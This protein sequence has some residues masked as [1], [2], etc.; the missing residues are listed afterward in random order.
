MTKE[1]NT[2]ALETKPKKHVSYEKS[3]LIWA[4]IFLAPWLIGFLLMFAFPMVESF[5]YSFY[6]MKLNTDGIM[7]YTFIGFQNYYNALQVEAIGSTIFKVEMLNTIQEVA[8][9]I[10]VIMIFSL[11][12][13][14][15]LNTE[16]KGR[17]I[18]RAIFFIPVILN[19]GAVVSAL[20]KGEAMS[21][22]L[23][24]T[25]AFGKVFELEEYLLRAGL[26]QGLVGFIVS[27]I[28]R[29]YSILSLSGVPIL[30]F[31]AS[32]QSVPRHLYEAAEIEGATKYE[33]FWLITLPNV[34]PHFLTVAIFILIDTFVSSPISKYIDMVKQT[35]WGLKASMSWLY[36]LVVAVIL[37]VIIAISKIFKWGELHE[38]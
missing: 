14:T 19:S 11:F 6:H 3:K 10:P 29:I 26:T 22:I 16:F 8:I 12:V 21:D 27:L 24:D 23:S 15:I 20:S 33:M 32:I 37:A 9:N 1:A 38:Q 31:L 25:G 30:L 18:V 2:I 13:A 35:Q 28:D 7:E 4:F 36:V 5:R 34:K 17:A